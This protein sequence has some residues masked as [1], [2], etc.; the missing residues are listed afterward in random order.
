[1]GDWAMSLHNGRFHARTIREAED[2][3][4]TLRAASEKYPRIEE[5]WEG[6]KWRLARGPQAGY[7]LPGATPTMYLIKSEGSETLQIPALTIL[8]AF[9]DDHVDIHSVRIS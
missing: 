7:K 9:D 6:W 4:P 5:V 1:M 3:E 8:Y 2:I